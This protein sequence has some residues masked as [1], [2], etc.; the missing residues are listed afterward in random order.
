[1]TLSKPVPLGI[2]D[3]Q[4]KREIKIPGGLEGTFTIPDM[5]WMKANNVNPAALPKKEHDQLMLKFIRT[6]NVSDP[7]Q[8]DIFNRLN[9][10]LLS[11]NAPL[12]QNEFLAMRA[13]VS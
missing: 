1:M 10:A 5:F 9:F 6:H 8:V 4:S 12:T 13:H 7:D 2:S 3:P 11:P